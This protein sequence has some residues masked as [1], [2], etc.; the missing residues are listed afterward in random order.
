VPAARKTNRPRALPFLAVSL[1]LI[2]IAA[3]ARAADAAWRNA[4]TFYGDDTEFGGPYRKGETIL[5]GQ[6]QSWI[7]VSLDQS[8]SILAG[9][10]GDRRSGGEKFLDR[11]DPILSFRYR[12]SSGRFIFGTLDTLRRHGLLDP[13]EVSTLELTRPIESGLQWQIDSK[14]AAG[15]LFLNW[16]KLNTPEHREVFDYGGTLRVPL[17]AGFSAELQAHGLHHG[18]QLYDVGPVTNNV[19]YG[20]GMAWRSE[21]RTKPSLA[22]H[23]LLSKTSR[24][25]AFPGRPATGRANRDFRARVARSRLLRGRRRSELRIDRP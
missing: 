4:V 22:V 20:G 24:D 13:L 8:A 17:P 1:L 11:I 6:F 23:E 10:F 9:V 3:P 2:V 18:G 5:G 16:Q 14:R 12:V 19:A 7:E 25:P 15:D 21:G